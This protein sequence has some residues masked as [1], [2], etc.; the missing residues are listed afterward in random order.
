MTFTLEV[1]SEKDS[2]G[3]SFGSRSLRSRVPHVA[4]TVD[5]MRERPLCPH[6]WRVLDMNKR[7]DRGDF[8]MVE[9]DFCHQTVMKAK[10]EKD[11]NGR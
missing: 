3:S 11:G 6:C 7:V 4:Q 8:W 2:D 10:A 1:A 5:I 9:C